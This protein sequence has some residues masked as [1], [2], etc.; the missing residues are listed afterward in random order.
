MLTDLIKKA[1]IHSEQYSKAKLNLFTP[2]AVIL[3]KYH[4]YFNNL[5][6]L[7]SDHYFS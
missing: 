1:F 6:T 5:R 3:P 2:N 7:Y 4:D